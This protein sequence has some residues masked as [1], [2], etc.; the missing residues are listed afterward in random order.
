[1]PA[2]FGAGVGDDFKPGDATSWSSG[3]ATF[4]FGWF[5]P[6]TLTAGR[7]YWGCTS[8]TTHAR[9]ATAT[10]EIDF[11]FNRTTTDA[12]WSST[13]AD[14]TVNNWWH[15]S[16]FFRSSG[17]AWMLPPNVW[18]GT[19]TSPPVAK[20]VTSSTAGSGSTSSSATALG[21][22]NTGPSD[23]NAFEGDIGHVGQMHHFNE[24]TPTLNFF[25]VD[26][27][28]SSALTTEETEHIYRTYVIPTWQGDI[29]RYQSGLMHNAPV[30]TSSSPCHL[31]TFTTLDAGGSVVDIRNLSSRAGS[32][33]D[34]PPSNGTLS[35]AT[36]STTNLKSP[37]TVISPATIGRTASRCGSRM[38]AR[39]VVWVR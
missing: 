5:Y 22:G 32:N 24:S 35:G 28:S 20:T 10:D 7:G 17:S 21:F 8:G 13:D 27:V 2:V 1:M 16:A 18:I 11:V 39:R 25:L 19:P 26:G 30:T 14:I 6:T 31:G 3:V 29:G 37:R 9:V 15:I 12:V 38:G 4:V 33:P 34:L 23:S 36:N